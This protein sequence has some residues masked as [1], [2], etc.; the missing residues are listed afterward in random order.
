MAGDVAKGHKRRL[1]RIVSQRIPIAINGL[2]AFPQ[3]GIEAEIVPFR[4][5]VRARRGSLTSS[6]PGA[7]RLAAALRIVRLGLWWVVFILQSLEFGDHL[8]I[9]RPP[10]GA[11]QHDEL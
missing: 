9:A 2:M 4:P 5:E 10:S 3:P 1:A 11:L 7:E 6:R 8:Q